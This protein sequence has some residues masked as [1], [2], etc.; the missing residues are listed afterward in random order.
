MQ[1]H[2]CLGCD[3]EQHHGREAS[4]GLVP[5]DCVC[6]DSIRGSVLLRTTCPRQSLPTSNGERRAETA[7]SSEPHAWWACLVEGSW[8]NLV[9]SERLKYI[10]WRGRSL[11]TGLNLMIYFCCGKLVAHVDIVVRLQWRNCLYL[12]AVDVVTK[13]LLPEASQHIYNCILDWTGESWTCTCCACV[14]HFFYWS[15]TKCTTRLKLDK[16]TCS[17]YCIGQDQCVVKCKGWDLFTTTAAPTAAATVSSSV[18]ACRM[19]MA[20]VLCQGLFSPVF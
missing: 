14:S 15:L 19:T 3:S 11:R 17:I 9:P 1:R 12:V 18:L 5:T 16:I 7:I 13:L 10:Y 6:A 20:I 4:A 2:L 8:L